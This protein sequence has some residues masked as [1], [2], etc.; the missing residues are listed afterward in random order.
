MWAKNPG[1]SSR[2]AWPSAGPASRSNAARPPTPVSGSTAGK[3]KTRSGSTCGPPGAPRNSTSR[4]I[5]ST[6]PCSSAAASP[7]PRGTSPR[8]RRARCRSYSRRSPAR[9]GGG[10]DGRARAGRRG[11][12]PRIRSG[13][14]RR[15]RARSRGSRRRWPRRI[16]RADSSE[17][18]NAGDFWAADYRACRVCQ[19]WTL[20]GCSGGAALGF[21]SM[22]GTR[23]VS[24]RMSPSG[25]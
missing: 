14:A 10:R 4:R 8:S 17:R 5:A 19:R 12:V 11:T 23:F 9:G 7:L 13:R 1:W 16:G 20:L 21:L 22:F 18:R 2:L 24:R 25:I 6:S 3:S 15:P